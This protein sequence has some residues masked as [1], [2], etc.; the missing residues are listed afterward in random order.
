[1]VDEHPR[2]HLAGCGQTAGGEE[3]PLPRAGAR[4]EGFTACGICRPDHHLAE[5]ERRRRAATE[6]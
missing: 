1:M 2:Y 5:A 3:L 6:P 4:A